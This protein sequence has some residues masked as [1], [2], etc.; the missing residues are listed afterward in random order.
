MSN[1]EILEKTKTPK[2]MAI[3]ALF[4]DSQAGI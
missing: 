4:E 3:N 1:G 2:F